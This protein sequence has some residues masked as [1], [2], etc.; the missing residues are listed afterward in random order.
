MT[1]FMSLSKL[2]IRQLQTPFNVAVDAFWTHWT[3]TKKQHG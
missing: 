1:E 2:P 3:A